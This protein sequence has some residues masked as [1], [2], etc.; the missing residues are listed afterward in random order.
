MSLSDPITYS[1]YWTKIASIAKR[2]RERDGYEPDAD[3]ID[4]LHEILD[5]HQWVIYTAYAFD[6]LRHCGG[7][8]HNAIFEAGI[9]TSNED[10]MFWSRA[11]YFAM[12]ADVCEHS[13]FSEIME[14]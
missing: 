8:N 7:D 13:E 12:H 14:E 5:G 1:E 3:Q 6:V 9:D 2:A 11:A 10:G 4:V